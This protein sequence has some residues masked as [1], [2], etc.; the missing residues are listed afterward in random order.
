MATDVIL[1]TSV[2]ID[3]ALVADKLSGYRGALTTITVA[4][5]AAGPLA[6]AT[7]VERA[8]RQQRLQWAEATFRR[9]LPFDL[10][11]ARSYGS[12]VAA[13]RQRGPGVRRRSHDL[14]IAAV[15]LS[16]QLPVAT[17]NP[18]DFDGLGVDVVELA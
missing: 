7:E 12:V 10:A 11:A 17:R 3:F 18:D 13:L 1:D 4:E 15:A 16:R 14:L 5:L 2:V 6:A 8:A 9:P